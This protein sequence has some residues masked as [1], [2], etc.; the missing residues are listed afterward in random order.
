MSISILL[1]SAVALVGA[2][3]PDANCVGVFTDVEYA[4]EYTQV[5]EPNPHLTATFNNSISSAL[6]GSN[7]ASVTFFDFEGYILAGPS[8]FTPLL[9]AIDVR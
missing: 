1:L 7:I 3:T 9:P 8:T 2:S 5:C 4:G 6:M